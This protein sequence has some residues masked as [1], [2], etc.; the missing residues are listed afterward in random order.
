M[1]LCHSPSNSRQGGEDIVRL[2]HGD[3]RVVTELPMKDGAAYDRPAY[4]GAA[5]EGQSRL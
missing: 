4:D 2:E 3:V 5:N 1:S